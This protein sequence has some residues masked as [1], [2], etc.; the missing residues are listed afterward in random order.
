MKAGMPANPSTRQSNA[1]DIS[2]DDASTSALLEVGSS[3]GG[4][5]PTA[6][7]ADIPVKRRRF[8]AKK[9]F[10]ALVRG[11]GYKDG[12]PVLCIP[13][14]AFRKLVEEIAA[15][16]KSDLRFQLDAMTTLQ[17]DAELLVIERF[18][19]CARLA[20]LCRKDT[21]RDE[22][23]NFLREDEEQMA[24]PYSGRS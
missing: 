15:T 11:K 8:S 22:H 23:W 18:K 7:T 3:S 5:S 10:D 13:R 14:L 9:A 1:A 4:T 2:T 16:N 12:R 19:R 20:E 24:L 17:E 21:V 6:S